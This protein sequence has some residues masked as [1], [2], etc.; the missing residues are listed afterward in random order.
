MES[1]YRITN[2]IEYTPQ[3]LAPP[4]GRGEISRD[5]WDVAANDLPAH[6]RQELS[7]ESI[8][9]LFSLIR[10]DAGR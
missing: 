6:A 8:S 2:R 3:L 10:R 4:N 1:K 9:H 7:R 5:L